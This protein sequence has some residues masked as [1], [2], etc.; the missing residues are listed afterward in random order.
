MTDARILPA[1]SGRAL[2]LS[3]VGIG[4]VTI[5]RASTLAA[6]P[7][8][9]LSP[10]AVARI[11]R[12]LGARQVVQ[13]VVTAARSDDPQTLLVG[14]AVDG[15]HAAS[16]VPMAA[17]PGPYRRLAALSALLATAAAAVGAATSER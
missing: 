5:A 1:G 2:A 13:G 16:M 11:V 7:W 14:A 3:Q 6:E 8:L 4:L 15:L 17:V 12:V 10:V 9:G